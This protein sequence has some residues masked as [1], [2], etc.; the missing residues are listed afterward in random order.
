MAVFLRNEHLPCVNMRVDSIFRAKEEMA[1]SLVFPRHA[2]REKNEQATK[3]V[4]KNSQRERKGVVSRP[5]S[6]EKSDTKNEST[7]SHAPTHFTVKT[8]ASMS[9]TLLGFTIWT[10]IFLVA[11]KRAVEVKADGKVE[12]PLEPERS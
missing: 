7:H 9:I 4:S 2:V 12:V 11:T 5:Y 3:C 1:P 8:Q 10:A 6:D